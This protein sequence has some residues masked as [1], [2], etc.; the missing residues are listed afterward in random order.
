MA[1]RADC[2]ATSRESATGEE[3]NSDSGDEG[4]VHQTR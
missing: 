2:E 3:R 1:D 4:D